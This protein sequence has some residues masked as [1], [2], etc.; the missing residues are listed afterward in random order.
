MKVSRFTIAYLVVGSVA[1]A[2]LGIHIF[3]NLD[4]LW[5]VVAYLIGSILLLA[6]LAIGAYKWE[7][8]KK[9]KT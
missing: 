1:L 2:L 3:A 7:K 5:D 6:D 4:F 9:T 8:E